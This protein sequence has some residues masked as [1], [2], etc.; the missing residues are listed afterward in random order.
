MLKGRLSLLS[1]WLHPVTKISL[2]SG[3]SKKSQIVADYMITERLGEASLPPGWHWISEPRPVAIRNGMGDAAPVVDRATTSTST[4]P[5]K[6]AMPEAT[7]TNRIPVTRSL[8]T[9]SCAAS[10]ADRR[11]SQPS[12]S[13]DQIQRRESNHSAIT[14]EESDEAD[15]IPSQIVDAARNA[16]ENDRSETVKPAEDEEQESLQKRMEAALEQQDTW[17][18]IRAAAPNAKA[19]AKK[20]AELEDEIVRLHMRLVALRKRSTPRLSASE[21][22]TPATNPNTTSSTSTGRISDLQLADGIAHPFSRLAGDKIRF[23]LKDPAQIQSCDLAVY[24]MRGVVQHVNGKPANAKSRAVSTILENGLRV[25]DGCMPMSGKVAMVVERNT[26][27]PASK[28]PQQLLLWDQDEQ[29]NSR[30]AFL[31]KAPHT[32]NPSCVVAVGCD[33]DGSYRFA[34]GGTTDRKVVLWDIKK[35]G[36]GSI[37]TSFIQ[38]HSSAVRSLAF[39]AVHARLFGGTSSGRILVQDLEQRSAARPIDVNAAIFHLHTNPTLSSQSIAVEAE[40]TRDQFYVYDVRRS[41]KQPT[42]RFGYDINAIPKATLSR[43]D[44]GSFEGNYFARGYGDG[45]VRMW[46]LRMVGKKPDRENPYMVAKASN[47]S[48]RHVVLDGRKLRVLTQ[49]A[50]TTYDL[51]TQT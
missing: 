9:Q 19:A 39:D 4:R 5:H 18:E 6:V 15:N 50:V 12:D 35:S 28:N 27:V 3:W 21:I 8:P 40:Q 42:H 16:G 23:M 32:G 49:S 14:V 30:Q 7:D 17:Q 45:T 29:G 26:V 22:E 51:A 25:V 13:I 46:D 11:A 33:D 24:S 48:I 31:P 41:S 36:G 2:D 37:K 10:E 34:S 44:K 1:K 47:D 43:F 20:L 38:H